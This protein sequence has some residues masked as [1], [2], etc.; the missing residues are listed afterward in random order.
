MVNCELWILSWLL[1]SPHCLL[2]LREAEW[3]G[4]FAAMAALDKMSPRKRKGKT[5]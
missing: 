1:T 4:L 3:R 5:Q 2:H